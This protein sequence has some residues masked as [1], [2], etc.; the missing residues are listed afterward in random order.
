MPVEVRGAGA[1]VAVP[2]E[3]PVPVG[4]G[5]VDERDPG[6]GAEEGLAFDRV[7]G[8]LWG[9]LFGEELLGGGEQSGVEAQAGLRVEAAVEAPHPV[10]VD[11]GS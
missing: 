4:G 10:G 7:V 11:P 9:D 3:V 8:R 2:V 5:A 1:S 6:S